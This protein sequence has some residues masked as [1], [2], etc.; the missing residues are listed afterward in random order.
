M[1]RLVTCLL[2]S[3]IVFGILT[4]RDM[5][6]I[7]NQEDSTKEFP[8]LKNAQPVVPTLRFRFWYDIYILIDVSN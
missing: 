7:E 1:E 5:S 2:V 3:A 8:E 6:A 4:I